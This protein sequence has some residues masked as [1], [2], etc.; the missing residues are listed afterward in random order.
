MRSPFVEDAEVVDGYVPINF[1]RQPEYSNPFQ[2]VDEFSEYELEDEPE[3]ESIGD[4]PFFEN[5]YQA[6][7]KYIFQVKNIC[8]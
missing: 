2:K 1:D 7:D 6:G 4:A 5:E 3:F 8:L